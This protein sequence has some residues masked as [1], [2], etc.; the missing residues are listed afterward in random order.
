MLEIVIIEKCFFLALLF[1]PVARDLV[2]RYFWNGNW[3]PVELN[4]VLF[5]GIWFLLIESHKYTSASVNTVD[6]SDSWSVFIAGH[7][8]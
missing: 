1:S 2:M 3:I 7:V 5:V 4:D 6:T 8:T